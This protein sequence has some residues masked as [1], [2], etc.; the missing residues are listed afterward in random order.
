MKKSRTKSKPKAIENKSTHYNLRNRSIS[1]NEAKNLEKMLEQMKKELIGEIS[2]VAE[3]ILNGHKNQIIN[4]F[5]ES[6]IKESTPIPEIYEEKKVTKSQKSK[7]KNKGSVSEERNDEKEEQSE[8][9]LASILKDIKPKKSTLSKKSKNNKKNIKKDSS[10][11][12]LDE[13]TDASGLND[14]SKINDIVQ[15]AVKLDKNENE[16]FTTDNNLIG[17]KRKRSKANCSLLDPVSKNDINNDKKNQK[18]NN[19]KRNLNSKS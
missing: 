1:S 10:P 9:N 8:N 15:K 7:K 6:K 3:N 19:S 16:E 5:I 4:S 14:I 18:K 12:T 13:K 11:P 17:K 2:K